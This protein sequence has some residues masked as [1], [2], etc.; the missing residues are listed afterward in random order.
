MRH[1]P[2]EEG[3]GGLTALTGR[4]HASTGE[5]LPGVLVSNGRAVRRTDAGGGFELAAGGSGYVFVTRPAGFTTAAWFHR[6]A[7]GRTRYDFTLQ[8]V[9]QPVPFAFV[10]V[11]DLHLGVDEE[12]AYREFPDSPFG[13]D[14]AGN[15]VYRPV[16]TAGDVAALLEEISSLPTPD[17]RG[18]AF[19]AATGDLTDRGVPSEYGALREVLEASPVPVEVLPGNH[20]HY[21][22]RYEPRPDDRP[23]DSFGMSTGTTTRYDEA[24]VGP[25]WWSMEYGGVHF[26]AIDWFSHRLGEDR[27]LQEEWLHADLAAQP[28]GT[29]VVLLVHDQMKR[30]FFARL[31]RAAPHVRLLGSFSGHWHTCRTVTDGG[32]IHANTGNATFG[33]CDFTP[34]QYRLCTWDGADLEVRTLTRSSPMISLPEA[35]TRATMR[36]PTRVPGDVWS[37]RL[38]GAAHMARPVVA[39][40]PAGEGVRDTV[41]AAW[42]NEDDP[43]GGV[44]TLDAATGEEMW[45]A[46]VASTVRAGTAY[47]PGGEGSSGVVVLTSVSGEVLALDPSS[48]ERLWHHQVGDPL[49]MWVYQEPLIHEDLVFVGDVVVFQALDLATGEVVWERADLGKPENYIPVAHPVIQADTLL[50]GFMDQSPNTWGLDPRTGKTRWSSGDEPLLAP[51]AAFLADPDGEHAY[52]IR[53]GG[54]AEKLSALSGARRWE[55]Q[56]DAVFTAGRPALTT[57]PD[58][59]GV[60]ATSGAGTV[61]RL[62]AATGRTTWRTELADEALLAM[63][64]YRKSGSVVVS[65]PTIT[66]RGILQGTCGGRIY[67]IDPASGEAAVVARLE[68]PV[69]A[70]LA[71]VGENDVVAVTTDG[72]VRRL[73]VAP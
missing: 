46:S 4:V 70:P 30:D 60:I 55:A 43:E 32:Q 24:G 72:V 65:G 58:A 71:P 67:R 1:R 10:Q 18:V 5:P 12:P 48:G 14:A 42:G 17:G 49:H 68:A 11:T 52:T 28:E 29:P 63:G 38:P 3:P 41:F 2:Q 40:L 9:E 51:M 27:A 16:S 6:V 33:S 22:H 34:P 19:V 57:P 50:L 73:R 26:A 23:V 21:G 62:D 15:R 37:I 7:D 36:P 45:R 61:Y 13:L 64:P 25:R 69:A 59:T 35:G 54:L 44:L 53:F 56:V 39:A 31:R 8:P 20:D 47:A 66:G